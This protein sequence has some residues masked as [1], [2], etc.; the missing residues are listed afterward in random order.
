[1]STEKVFERPNARHEKSLPAARGRLH[2]ACPS[3]DHLASAGGGSPTRSR[4][5]P[6]ETEG[7]ILMATIQSGDFTE[8]AREAGVE[9]PHL[10]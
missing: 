5:L 9:P 2:T 1:M 3:V 8:A 7:S 6:S 10:H 4:C